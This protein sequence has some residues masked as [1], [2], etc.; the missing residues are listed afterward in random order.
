MLAVLFLFLIFAL[1][2]LLDFFKAYGSQ[3]LPD[4]WI[5]MIGSSTRQENPRL[6]IFEPNELISYDHQEERA[7]S[8]NYK[9]YYSR[10]SR[11]IHDI[12]IGFDHEDITMASPEAQKK[13]Q[14]VEN[15]LAPDNQNPEKH[16][17]IGLAFM[18]KRG[19]AAVVLQ[20][21]NLA[22][23][24]N[25]P[26]F[27]TRFSITRDGKLPNN[28]V[29][30]VHIRFGKLNK[31]ELALEIP[32]SRRFYRH[33]SLYR[34]YTTERT[35]KHIALQSCPSEHRYL[36]ADCATFAYNFLRGVLGHL[37][38]QGDITDLRPHLEVLVRHNHIMDGSAGKSEVASR[39]NRKLG[40]SS[41]IMLEVVHLIQATS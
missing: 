15:F 8:V 27:E 30:L 20:E 26:R 18:G 40:Q 29:R 25:L 3:N 17:N 23:D 32:L 14:L 2:A 39:G 36:V 35:L 19:H 28:N 38:N 16:Y 24:G 6:I 37:K 34:I 13:S 31:L 4:V 1:L 7:K 21:C 41:N 12:P 11:Q 22:A 5:M 9:E 10:I 33:V